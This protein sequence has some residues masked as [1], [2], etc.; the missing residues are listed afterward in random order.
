[1]KRFGIISTALVFCLVTSAA[2]ADKGGNKHGNNGKSNN[3]HKQE[4]KNDDQQGNNSERPE[5]WDHGKKV[6]W[7][8]CNMP[9]GQA[10]KSGCVSH[11][12]QQQLIS[13]Q[14]QRVSRYRQNLTAQ[15]LEAAQVRMAALRQNRAAQFQFQ[16]DYLERLRQQQA[17]LDADRNHDYS[18]DPYFFTPN[19]YSYNQAGRSYQTNQY[20][21][22]LLKQA[23][24]NGYAEGLRTGQADR[25]DRFASNYRDTYAYQNASL[26]YNGYVDQSQYSYYFRQGFQRGY[27]DGYGNQTQFGTSSNGTAGVI[28]AVLGQILNFQNLRQ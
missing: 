8:D 6:G 23:V 21:A 12:R 4:Q 18:S 17:R 5:G 26:G 16:Q 20:G 19:S 15:Q 2:Y 9:P 14:Q 3:G 1:M 25:Q 13:M 10:R 11:Q 27:Q 22:D 28:A 7:G 24:N